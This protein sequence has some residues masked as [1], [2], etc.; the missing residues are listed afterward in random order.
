MLTGTF[1]PS[2]DTHCSRTTSTS[3]KSTGVFLKS[4]V[5][6]SFPVFA[7]KRYQAGGSR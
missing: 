6:S 4:A 2:F 7:V 5:F 3:P 1:V